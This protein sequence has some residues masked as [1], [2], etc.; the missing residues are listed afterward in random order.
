MVKGAYLG[1]QADGNCQSTLL[2][3]IFSE[4]DLNF[5]YLNCS[6]QEESNSSHRGSDQAGSKI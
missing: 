6:F 1:I 2:I 3:T 4:T 5:I